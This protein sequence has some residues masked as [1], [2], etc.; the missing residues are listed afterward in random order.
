MSSALPFLATNGNV[1]PTALQTKQ[2]RLE[3]QQQNR[4]GV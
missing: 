2:W 1:S 3:R 4:L